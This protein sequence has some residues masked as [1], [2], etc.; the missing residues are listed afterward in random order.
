[1]ESEAVRADPE[2]QA[3]SGK[4]VALVVGQN[5]Y[6]DPLVRPLEFAEQDAAALSGFLEHRAGFEKVH[7]L[8]AD[9][10]RRVLRAAA[11]LTANLGRGDLF[12]FFLPVTG[13]NSTAGICCFAKVPSGR[14]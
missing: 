8:R 5:Q 6:D 3:P 10:D 1:M 4:R 14:L 12:V 13:L 2:A 7:W 9:D 11:D